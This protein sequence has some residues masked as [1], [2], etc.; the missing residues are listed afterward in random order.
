MEGDE[1]FDERRQERR[2]PAAVMGSKK[3]GAVVL[4]REI[5]EGI[6]GVIERESRYPTPV[7]GP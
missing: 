6:Q 7:R 1:D 4:P 5:E 3:I 2:S